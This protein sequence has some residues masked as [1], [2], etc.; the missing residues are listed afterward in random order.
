MGLFLFV[1]DHGKTDLV[2]IDP[3]KIIIHFVDPCLV[4]VGFL[5]R[6]IALKE[7]C[8]HPPSGSQVRPLKILSRTRSYSFCF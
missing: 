7:H 8:P 6:T 5:S 2:S 4:S 1:V 3:E